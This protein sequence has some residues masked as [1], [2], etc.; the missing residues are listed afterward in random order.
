MFWS[1]FLW[2][3]VIKRERVTL[4]IFLVLLVYLPSYFVPLLFVGWPSIRG[5]LADEPSKPRGLG[6]DPGEEVGDLVIRPSQ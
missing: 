2:G 5:H 3:Y 4:L 1:I 6:Q